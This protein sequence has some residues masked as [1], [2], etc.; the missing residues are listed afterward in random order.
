[1][2]PMFNLTARR[3]IQAAL[4]A[5]IA[6]VG[7][8]IAAGDERPSR[9]PTTELWRV[10]DWF[11][12]DIETVVVAQSFSIPKRSDTPKAA[13]G[14][15]AFLSSLALGELEDDKHIGPLAGRKVLIAVNGMRLP[16]VT[17]KFGEFY[18][19]GC[20][21][22]VF[23]R[24][25]GQA[26]VDW[27]NALRKEAKEIRKIAGR[28]VLCFRSK[29]IKAWKGPGIYFVKLAPDTILCATHDEFLQQLLERI[30]TPPHRGTPARAFPD[31]LPEWTAID[32]SAP[33]WMI[34]HIPA[35]NWDRLIHGVT[36]TWANDQ[37]R[38]VFLPVGS[39][40][41]KVLE[42]T[43]R[44]WEARM[45]NADT[46]GSG[47]SESLKRVVHCELGNG[48]VTVSFKTD[49]QMDGPVGFWLFLNLYNL[50]HEDGSIGPQ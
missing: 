12:E 43:R 37:A 35:T 24:D 33:V 26:A 1:M 50:Q 15:A 44:R 8:R 46:S 41:K 17:G 38:V 47:L 36:W 2:Q 14:A 49:V 6:L 5:A 9:K 34:R 28:E 30:D 18:A 16:R 31:G 39:S 11:P 42:E 19:E 45:D 29:E 48:R 4:V 40:A 25:L 23:D 20:S 22:I 3:S 32:R 27:T 21:I 10:L 7:S 13:K